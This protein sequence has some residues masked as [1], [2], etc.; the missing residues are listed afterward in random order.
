VESK[1][2]LKKKKE[3]KR[4]RTLTERKHRKTDGQ[5]SRGLRG[6]DRAKSINE[7]E[8]EGSQRDI[9]TKQVGHSR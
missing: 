7:K 5:S 2:L 1:L 6:K 4:L 8:G 9:E 3:R